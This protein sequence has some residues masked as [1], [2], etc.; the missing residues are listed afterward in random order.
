MDP[1]LK[2]VYLVPLINRILTAT[3]MEFVFTEQRTSVAQKVKERLKLQ[4]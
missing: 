2:F 1:V 3:L 4:L